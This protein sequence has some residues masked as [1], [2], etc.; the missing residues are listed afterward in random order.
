MPFFADVASLLTGRKLEMIERR[1]IWYSVAILMFT[2]AF[3][4]ASI[5]AFELLASEFGLVNAGIIM[6]ALFLALG[7]ISVMMPTLLP[8]PEPSQT[9]QVVEVVEEEAQAVADALGPIQLAASAFL[10]GL[11]AGRRVRGR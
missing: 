2:I 5:W 9:E 3:I 4:I 10:L 7:A 11:G 1:V 8:E 6:I